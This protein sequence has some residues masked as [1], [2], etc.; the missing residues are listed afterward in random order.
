MRRWI[1]GGGLTLALLLQPAPAVAGSPGPPVDGQSGK[2]GPH[3]LVD[4]EAQPAG[5]CRYDESPTDDDLIRLRVRAPVVKARAGRPR[6]RVAWRLVAQGFDGTSWHVVDAD[7]WRA[8]EATPSTPAALTARGLPIDV[9]TAHAGWF[10][11]RVELRWYARDG[12]TLVG[13]AKLYPRW[14]TSIYGTSV[15][16]PDACSSTAG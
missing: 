13:R 2:V 1:A 12:H 8:G 14:Y 11:A 9:G 15:P 3:H 6:Q 7:A 16:V 10:R 4:S 5:T